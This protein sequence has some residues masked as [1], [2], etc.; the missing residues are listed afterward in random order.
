MRFTKFKRSIV[1]GVALAACWTGIGAVNTASADWSATTEANT[2]FRCQANCQAGGVGPV[3]YGTFLSPPEIGAWQRTVAIR[4]KTNTWPSRLYYVTVKDK[5][6][7]GLW[8]I[9]A[10][11]LTRGVD[12]SGFPFCS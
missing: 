3:D 11:M 6:W 1:L 7:A 5:N 12:D 9:N 4:C 10:N 2:W 8:M